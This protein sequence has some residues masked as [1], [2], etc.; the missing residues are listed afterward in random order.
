L[1]ETERGRGQRGCRKET[2]RAG[3][4]KTKGKKVGGDKESSRGM[5]NLEQREGGGKVR[6]GG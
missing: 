1:G 5:K 6:S 2:R 4:E 3:E